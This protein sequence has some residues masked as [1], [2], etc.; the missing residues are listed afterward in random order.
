M[1]TAPATFL[2]HQLLSCYMTV[3][4]CSA[5]HQPTKSALPDSISTVN[6]M[7]PTPVHN[8]QQHDRLECLSGQPLF[9]QVFLQVKK[10]RCLFYNKTRRLTA[11]TKQTA[12]RQ[13]ALQSVSHTGGINY[14]TGISARRAGGA[15]RLTSRT[16][17]PLCL[18]TAG[19]R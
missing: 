8:E 12:R 3:C 10:L 5:T 13:H 1:L 6:S 14:T 2:Q 17:W 4:L 19:L 7:Q 16:L 15:H 18:S 9:L 11:A